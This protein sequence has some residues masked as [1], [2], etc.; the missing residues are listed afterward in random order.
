MMR[1]AQAARRPG[2][3]RRWAGG[4]LVA[5]SVAFLGYSAVGH[6]D[7]LRALPWSGL[8]VAQVAAAVTAYSLTI[9]LHGLAW[10]VW[11]TALGQ[12]VAPASAVMI[13]A[14]S[15]VAKY[16]PGNVGHWIG[17]VAMTVQ[18]GVPPAA[19]VYALG[20]ETLWALASCGLL[21]SAVW[22]WQALPEAAGPKS[23]QAVLGL[24]SIGLGLLLAHG[25]PLLL[26]R[27]PEALR[28]RIGLEG[29]LRIPGLRPSLACLGLYA[30]SWLF[31]G[32]ALLWVVEGLGLAPPG[33]AWAVGVYAA[34]WLTGYLLPG[35]P[36][37]LGAREAV[38]LLLLQPAYGAGAGLGIALLLRAVN[39]LGDGLMLSVGWW[40]RSRQSGGID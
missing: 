33:L 30:S 17:R 14:V 19:A 15:Q 38:L 25:L 39:L 7:E 27:L 22:G 5:L 31:N 13:T 2:S 24:A 20:L 3:M 9:V 29:R 36:G 16:L 1:G 10:H 12:G 34:A 23:G 28:G 4:A 32:L 18:R 11:L 26:R 40:M 35:A 8:G 21:L 37:G 6:F